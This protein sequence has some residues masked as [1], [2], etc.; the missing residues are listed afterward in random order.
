MIEKI[1]MTCGCTTDYRS[2][3][4]VGIPLRWD[5]DRQDQVRRLIGFDPDSPKVTME[6]ARLWQDG[7][8]VS[9]GAAG[10]LGY[11]EG[12][13]EYVEEPGDSA[14]T[15]PPQDK[16]P[17]APSTTAPSVTEVRTVSKLE[18]NTGRMVII[19]IAAMVA[20]VAVGTV[21]LASRRRRA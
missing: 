17:V 15:G 16:A 11:T 12:Y 6:L 8:P 1:G 4:R 14:A 20:V 10:P 7:P 18:K 5:E 21:I 13:L 9:D 3:S 2:L 19:V